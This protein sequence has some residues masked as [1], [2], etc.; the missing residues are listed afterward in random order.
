MKL[1]KLFAILAATLTL[2]NVVA[3]NML[4][5]KG[6]AIRDLTQKI[7]TTEH[8]NRKLQLELAKR[9]SLLEVRQDIEK[10]G[11]SE[12]EKVIT[13]QTPHPVALNE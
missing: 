8:A 4:V 2:A 7:A 13:L 6:E 1:I 9:A 10:A 12:P 11:F 3:S 5:G